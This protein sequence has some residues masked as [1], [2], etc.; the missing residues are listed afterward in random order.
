MVFE[1]KPRRSLGSMPLTCSS[2][3]ICEAKECSMRSDA[4]DADELEW[5]Q[6]RTSRRMFLAG[7]ASTVALA[8]LAAN[9]RVFAQDATADAT[10]D[11]ATATV[12]GCT[13]LTPE[14]T[15]GPYYI[16]DALLRDDITED[17]PGIVLDLKMTVLDGVSCEPLSDVAVDIWH[18]DAAGDYSGLSGGMGNDDTSGE[19]W[20]RGI[21]LTG[22]DGVA[23]IR[24][25]YPGWYQGRATHIHLKI[26]VGGAAEDGTYEGGTVAHTGQLFFDDATTD[27]IAKIEP[28]ASRD[29]VRVRNEDDGVFANGWEEPG[30]FVDLTANDAG[31]LSQGFVG[32]VTLY[33]DPSAVSEET[34]MGGGPQGGPGNAG[35]GMPPQGRPSDG[36][37]RPQNP[38]QDQ[39][40]DDDTETSSL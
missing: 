22:T 19:T 3:V 23:A 2:C 14:R 7:S 20:L 8:T 17:R 1:T 34:G 33:I 25:I 24:T 28:Y 15:E 40:D 10:A 12:V 39:E 37:N 18:C 21:Q 31:D 13:T 11:A 30:F 6:S 29:I 26:H 35:G 38:G 27:E 5:R 32:T 36:Q 9:H 4:F 16:E